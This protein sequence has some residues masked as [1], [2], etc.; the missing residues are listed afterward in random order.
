MEQ[1]LLVIS[2]IRNEAAHFERTARALA[3][4]TR[5]PDLWLVVDDN[6]TD[7][8][9]AILARLQ[10]ELEFM[11]VVNGQA[12]AQ[13]DAPKDRLAVA[14]PPR[15]FNRGLGNADWTSFT[16]IAKL[17]GDV[18]LPPRYFELLLGEFASDPSLGLAGG[19][20]QERDGE[21]WSEQP[22]A[23]DYHVRG[24]L[25]CYSRECLEAIGGIQER[26]AWD[27]IDE[28]YARMRGFRTRTVLALVA[29]HHRPTA[30][31][32]GLVRGRARHGRCAYI[33][34]FTLPWVTLRSFK[35]ARERPRGLSGVAFLYGYLRA[36]VLR[37]PRVEDPEFRDFVRRE[38]R[39][40]ARSE[41]AQRLPLARTALPL[42][43]RGH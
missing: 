16:H 20:L 32:D 11:T 29:H 7:E 1:R 34:R 35:V 9:P 23:N 12:P 22:G 41:I 14:A 3:A 4:Q 33:V 37:T 42:A 2:P 13:Q 28:I 18:E 15:A 10:G 38:L 43:D 26:L 21:G 17:D 39:Q 6:S 5:R 30:S 24:G 36:A 27:A 25:K 40:R 8:T 19:V 31:A